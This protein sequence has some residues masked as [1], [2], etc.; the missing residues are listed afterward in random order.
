[1]ELVES[2]DVEPQ[3]LQIQRADYLL[4]ID[5]FFFW[6]YLFIYLFCFL[7]P[8]PQHMKDPRLGSSRLGTVE[9]NLTRNHEVAGSIPGLA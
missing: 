5:F 3:I 6:L 9:T 7:G 8:H 2:T 1:M 4:Y